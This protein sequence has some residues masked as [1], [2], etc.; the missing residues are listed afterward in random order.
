MVKEA[1]TKKTD[2]VKKITKPVAKKAD[3]EVV[4]KKHP[5]KKEKYY[6]AIG[7]RKSAI[8][9]VRLFTKN[10]AFIFGSPIFSISI[11]C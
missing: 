8:A 6:E 5:P 4:E 7:R 1:K 10:K 11:G 9:R 2:E 3:S